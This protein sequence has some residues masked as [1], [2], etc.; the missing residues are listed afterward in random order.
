[1]LLYGSHDHLLKA[2][3]VGAVALG[4]AGQRG[5]EGL[6]LL[7]IVV[8]L[9]IVA[10]GNLAAAQLHIGIVHHQ[11]QNILLLLGID[12]P[13]LFSLQI[14]LGIRHELV[15][16]LE[17]GYALHKRVVQNR[18]LLLLHRI[19]INRELHS[20]AGQSGLAVVLRE[21]QVENLVVALLGSDQTGLKALDKPVGAK[22]QIHAVAGS[23]CK[24]HAVLGAYII[25]IDNIA[26]LGRAV[27]L[28][29]VGVGVHDLLDLGVNLAL[30]YLPGSDINFY[31]LIL[32]QLVTA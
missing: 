1:M 11:A 19:H 7:G 5:A 20:L 13:V 2:S 27:H 12:L 24:L 10:L 8:Q 25:N 3:L 22:G 18:V 9:L 28:N 32:S 16:S 23:P 6:G 30:G 21:G 15:H 29:V 31:S 4:H 26:F 17:G 14:G